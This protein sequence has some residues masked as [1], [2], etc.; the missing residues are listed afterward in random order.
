MPTV[1]SIPSAEDIRQV[2]NGP[3]CRDL[4]ALLAALEVVSRQVEAAIIEAVRHGD[5]TGAW[6]YDSHR[7]VAPWLVATSGISRSSA[8][9]RARVARFRELGLHAWADAVA[10]A[11]LGIEQA[12]A[13]GRTAANPRVREHLSDSESLLLEF[14][15][16]MPYAKFLRVLEHWERLADVDGALGDDEVTD[17]NRTLKMGFVG[18]EFHFKGQ[19]GAAQGAVIAQLLQQFIDAEF[20]ADMRAAA[21]S[22]PSEVGVGALSRTPGQRRLDALVTALEHAAS[23]DRNTVEPVVNL[24]CDTTTLMEWLRFGIGGAHPVPDPSSIGTRRCDAM[25]E[26]PIDP[27]VM[28]EA[29]LSGRVRTVVMA[30]DGSVQSISRPTRFFDR[31]T[32]DAIRSIDGGCYWPGCTAPALSC[33]ID[34]L[35]PHAH[36]GATTPSNAGPACHRHNV[37]KSDR[38]YS[39]RRSGGWEI[40]RPDGS[41]LSD[42]PPR[43]PALVRSE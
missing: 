34:H 31:A 7:S 41:T 28:L 33:E 43:G 3:E 21:D 8:N 29:A 37:F 9:A 17:R 18:S 15:Q 38:W 16:S 14:A 6:A 30:G 36:G 1:I 24:V 11:S 32:R 12:R 13:L 4:D 20:R 5:D 39:S 25:G 2:R 35:M 22:D 23:S 42:A 19:C 27:R 26:A 40:Q 10:N